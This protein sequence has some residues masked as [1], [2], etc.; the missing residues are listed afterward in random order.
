M[1]VRPIQTFFTTQEQVKNTK[2]KASL[3]V[4]PQ[5][6]YTVNAQMLLWGAAYIGETK[7]ALKLRIAEY[8]GAIRN[9]NTDYA[10]AR[11]IICAKEKAQL[12]PCALW[13]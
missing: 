8:K 2:S 7:R 6:S 11:H 4:A 5:T 13:P 12:P 3:I 1:T 9:K 10:I